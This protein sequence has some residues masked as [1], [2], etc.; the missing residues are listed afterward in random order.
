M[1]SFAASSERFG[2]KW[3]GDVDLAGRATMPRALSARHD[4]TRV[5]A[6]DLGA[7]SFLDVGSLVPISDRTSGAGRHPGA[8]PG[9]DVL[10]TALEGAAAPGIV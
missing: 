10:V 7:L 5:V 6:L 1:A 2:L 3:G 8:S 9:A 4:A